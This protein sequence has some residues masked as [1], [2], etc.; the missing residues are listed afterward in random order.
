[1]IPLRQVSLPMLIT[2]PP[3]GEHQVQSMATVGGMMKFTYPAAWLTSSSNALLRLG[4][5]KERWAAES[6]EDCESQQSRLQHTAPQDS[7][8]LGAKNQV[9]VVSITNR[10]LA[11]IMAS[12]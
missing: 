2:T 4:I 12:N 10:P 8:T 6:M 11:F 5:P 1:V 7:P 3:V 9:K